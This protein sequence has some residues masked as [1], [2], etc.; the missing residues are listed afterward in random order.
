MELNRRAFLGTM[1]AG[2]LGAAAGAAQSPEN[3]GTSQ[4]TPVIDITDLY[5]PPQDPGDNVDLIAAYALPEINLKAVIFDVTER[6][7]RAYVN[8]ENPGYDDPSGGRDPGYVPVIQLNSIF[9]RDVPCAPGPYTPMRS[10]EDRM[11]D[12]PAFQQ[13]GIELILRTL[14]ESPVP[15]DI[16]SF[17]SARPLAVAFNRAPDLLREK[18]RRA[19]LCAGSAPPGYLEW[20]VN[21]DVHAFVRVLRSGL[22]LAIYPC[23]TDQSATAL[24]P[25]N[26]YWSLPRF[27]LIRTMTPA[28]QRYLAFAFQRTQRMDFLAALE[29]DVPEVVLD[30]IAARPHNVWETDVWMHVAN[31]RLVRRA[32]GEYRILPERAVLTGDTIVSSELRPCA[33]SVRD[34]GQFTFTAADTEAPIRIFHRTDPE[35]HQRAL[36][37][38]MP[39]LYA[40]FLKPGG[41]SR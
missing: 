19:Y 30:A 2:T 1:A 12:V 5:H 13:T 3:P 25:H 32:G 14:R 16:V 21:L 34:D 39:A 24:G 36:R 35:E 37:E 17:G 22:P 8:P 31:R 23:A 6:Y 10:P 11:E 29:E 28:L 40:S 41:V 15:V 26:T 9:G 38:A 27:D 20:N 7:R 4:R 33:V 18:M